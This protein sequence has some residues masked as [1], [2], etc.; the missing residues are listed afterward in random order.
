MDRQTRIAILMDHFKRP[1]HRGTL[2][3]ADAS[4][5][6][7][8]PDCGDVV[9][10]HLRA[11]PDERRI[12]EV[13]FEGCGCTISQA[14]ASILAERVNKKQPDFQTIE[15]MTYEEMID[16][17]GRDIVGS[18]PR[19]ATLALGTLKAAVRRV[20]MDRKLRAAGRSEEEIRQMRQLIEAQAAGRDLVIGEA[21]KQIA[22]PV[23]DHDPDF[24]AC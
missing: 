13:S 23:P 17:L 7:G 8:N 10:I 4:I 9:T 12:A 6:G 14:A 19:C 1:R 22:G 15:D 2:E 5:P 24:I 16:L 3:N 18:R 20:D 11:H 21:A